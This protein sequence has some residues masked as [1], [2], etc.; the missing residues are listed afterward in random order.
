M[1]N[2]QYLVYSPKSSNF[3]ECI[4]VFRF[5]EYRKCYRFLKSALSFSKP[6]LN[7]QKIKMPRILSITVNFGCRSYNVEMMKLR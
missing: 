6:R 1:G 7:F 4:I 3:E 2:G 5:W